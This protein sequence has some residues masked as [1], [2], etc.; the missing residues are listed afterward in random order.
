MKF[1]NIKNKNGFIALS[2]VLI[3]TFITILIISS[4]TIQSIS[5]LQSSSSFYE[6]KQ[7]FYN[8]SSCAEYILY[9][10][11]NDI[12]HDNSGSFQINT[13]SI[14]E[15]NI[16]CNNLSIQREDV[17]QEAVPDPDPES[18]DDP[19]LIGQIITVTLS[20]GSDYIS[21]KRIVISEIN[22]EINI[23]SFSTE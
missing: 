10:L 6:Y 19:I 18:G 20:S 4:I 14:I 8:S 17:F 7:S 16:L 15:E 2:S 12:N 1:N 23:D 21:S 11:M 13:N 22:S 3:I 5:D 9:E